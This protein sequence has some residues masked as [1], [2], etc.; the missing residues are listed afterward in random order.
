MGDGHGVLGGVPVAQ[1]GASPHLYER[2]KPGEHHVDLALVQRPGVEHHVHVRVGGC[3]L[4]PGQLVLP[5]PGQ[6]RQGG[7]HRGGLA[8]LLPDAPALLKPPLAQHPHQPGL[9]PRGQDQAFLEHGAVVVP[10]LKGARTRPPLHR[11]GIGLCA[12]RAQEAV[13]EAVKA[14]RVKGRG[15]KLVGSLIKQLVVD[16]AVLIPAPGTVQRHL[17][18]LVVDGN[19]VVG[20][21]GI[22]IDAQPPRPA[23]GIVQRQIPQLHILPPGDEQRLG[24]VNPAPRALVYRVAQ[25][26]AAAVMPQL[27]A[28]GLPGHG[29][30]LPRVVVPEI[31]IVSRPVH[32]HAVG[33]EPGDPMV[34]RALIEEIPPGGVVDHSGH[35]LHPQVIGPGHRHIHPVYDILPLFPIKVP[36]VHGSPLLICM[37]RQCFMLIIPAMGEFPMAFYA[38]C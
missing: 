30:V 6:I 36:I 9:L 34:L 2:G 11:Q 8:V 16:D 31:D 19:L 5:E 37:F 4:E 1:P 12:V 27:P 7:V 22:G 24:S 23:G 10:L 3:D 25:P 29:P 15:H 26:V 32:G 35:I 13:P 28:A 18:V 38:F 33:A 20:E 21:L 14:V 17:E